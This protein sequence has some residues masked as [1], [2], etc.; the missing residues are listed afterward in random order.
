MNSALAQAAELALPTLQQA[1]GN[2][3]PK[4]KP[5]RR[6]VEAVALDDDGRPIRGRAWCGACGSRLW[7]GSHDFDGHHWLSRYFAG[8]EAQQPPLEACP[9]C[10][11]GFDPAPLS[12]LAMVGR[13]DA[14]RERLGTGGALDAEAAA[15][16]AADLEMGTTFDDVAALCGRTAEQLCAELENFHA[17][18]A[19]DL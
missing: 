4:P 1:L 15:A 6:I 13:I 3:Q 11:H 14:A 19:D 10:D 17:P 9:S 18:P 5:P 8:P 16:L 12:D 2:W 7:L